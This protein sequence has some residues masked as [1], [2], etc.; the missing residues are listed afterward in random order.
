M[1]LFQ[2]AITEGGGLPLLPDD[3][4]AVRAL[5]ESNHALS[6]FAHTVA[7][8]LKG[9][10]RHIAT[11][12][13]MLN[14]IYG[15]QLGEQGQ[16][17]TTRLIVNSNRAVRLIEDLLA[18]AE[19]KE[20]AEEKTPVNL[21]KTL[22]EILDTLQDTVD[23]TGAVVTS[24]DLPTIPAFPHRVQ[25]LL[26]NLIVNALTYRSDIAPRIS[27]T[28]VA[29]ENEYLFSVQDNGIGIERQYQARVFEPFQRLHSRD[30]IEGSGLGLAICRRVIDLHGGKLWMESEGGS[31]STFFFTL[32]KQ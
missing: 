19:A 5:R 1:T 4:D 6:G 11:Y 10:L 7:H 28:V 32:P 23:E 3:E 22:V 21:N 8:D 14:D 29:L 31:G 17:F 16:K 20:T 9:P 2:S 30:D 24:S 15:A 12:S 27:V 25:Q 26:Q 18:Y 13:Q